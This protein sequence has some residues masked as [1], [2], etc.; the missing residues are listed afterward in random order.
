MVQTSL[1]KKIDKQSIAKIIFFNKY[2]EKEDTDY[3][4]EEFG[5]TSNNII[6]ILQGY[7][8]VGLVLKLKQLDQELHFDWSPFL[9]QVIIK[10][11]VISKLDNV[12]LSKD[13]TKILLLTTKRLL[14][15][16]LEKLNEKIEKVNGSIRHYNSKIEREKREIEHKLSV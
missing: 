1:I 5:F 14:K 15:I 6:Y 10:S 13:S 12:F 11:H 4:K 16:D 7:R 8:N 3:L 9:T 2:L